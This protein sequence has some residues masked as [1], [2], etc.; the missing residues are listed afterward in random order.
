MLPNNNNNNNLPQFQK[1]TRSICLNPIRRKR[2]NCRHHRLRCKSQQQRRDSRNP[3]SRAKVHSTRLN[4]KLNPSK[5][6]W[7]LRQPTWLFLENPQPHKGH[8]SP[9]PTCWQKRKHS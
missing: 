5:N 9:K 1:Q 6:Q 3:S 8:R 4:R 2:R 7:R